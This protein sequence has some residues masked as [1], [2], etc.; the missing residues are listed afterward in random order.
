MVHSFH[1]PHTVVKMSNRN[2]WV[3]FEVKTNLSTR[4]G[5]S[6]LLKVNHIRKK[7]SQSFSD[8]YSHV[9]KKTIIHSA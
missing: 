2:S 6:A 5:F 8:R 3:D 9:R 4:N 7:G 1:H